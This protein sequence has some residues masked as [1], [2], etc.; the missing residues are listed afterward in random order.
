MASRQRGPADSP[1]P[2]KLAHGGASLN[3][4]RLYVESAI[5]RADVHPRDVVL[6]DGLAS[7]ATDA[8]P[9]RA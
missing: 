9:S 1:V 8:P 2:V 4:V 6:G 3:G 5:G 7:D